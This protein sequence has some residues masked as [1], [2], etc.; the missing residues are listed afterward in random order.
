MGIWSFYFFGK[1]FLY[2]AKYIDF[3][4]L[5]NLIFA[6]ALLIPLRQRWLR[7]VR[8]VIA[9][10][11]G[12]A[13][14]YHDAWLP[15]AEQALSKLPLL[16]QFDA[17]YL[18]ELVG[19]FVSG[20][21]LLILL[22]MYLIFALLDRKLRMST[23]AL[24]G[25]LSVPT[26]AFVQSSVTRVVTVSDSNQTEIP[27]IVAK[28]A[29]PTTPEALDNTLKR[30]YE[31]EANRRVHFSEVGQG[32]TPFDI[33]LLHT[34]SLAWDD[35]DF[36]NLLSHP[37]LKRFD[38]VFDNFNSAASYSGPAAI[39]VLRG[40]CGQQSHA[41]LYAPPNAECLL[42]RQLERV[43]FE[44]AWE[45]N[46]N[47]MFGGFSE[48]VI[49]NIG[50]SAR[51]TEDTSARPTQRSFDGSPIRDDYDV[52]SHWWLL[53]QQQS[54]PRMALFYNGVS[55]HDG[56]R[57]IGDRP[58]S[59]A[60]YYKQRLQN[61]LDELERF[62]QL[63]E[64]SG[65]RVVLVLIPEHG[66][67]IRGDRMQISGLREIPTAAISLVPTGVSLIGP[68]IAHAA[69]PV[70]VD[71]PT[72]YLALSEML[73][74]MIATD[75][76]QQPQPP[77]ADYVRNLPQTAMVAENENTVIMRTGSKYMMRTPDGSWSEYDTTQ[78]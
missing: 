69:A 25:I 71:G 59:T 47:G 18:L 55:L 48:D 76:F 37:F 10:P 56:N 41:D 11:V 16:M 34:C 65:R 4:F 22:G 27:G 57:A 23:F 1:L 20:Q 35:V 5:P 77:L 12:I 30:F 38:I 15:P 2:F 70:N 78:R 7:V 60:E 21:I 14:L 43:G 33:I 68:E 13:L 67:N 39:R 61:Y 31:A 62:A 49:A 63:L 26:I 54:V 64:S 66:A 29:V 45:M 40:T 17:A 44:S 3:H 75:P 58:K 9:V 42:M 73:S 50:T 28:D 53:R 46:H 52:L 72:S 36:A 51:F 19:R 24:L 8:Q 6:I 74:R 32:D